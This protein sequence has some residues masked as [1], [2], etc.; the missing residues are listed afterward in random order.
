MTVELVVP[1]HNYMTYDGENRKTAV[2]SGGGA[3][4]YSHDGN[5]MRVVKSI[6][7]RTTTVSIFSGSSLRQRTYRTLTSSP[8]F[9]TSVSLFEES[10][11]LFPNNPVGADAGSRSRYRSADLCVQL[12]R[13]PGT[14]YLRKRLTCPHFPHGN[15]NL[16]SRSRSGG[17]VGNAICVFK[18]GGAH[19]FS[20]A[21]LACKLCRRPIVQAAVWSLFVVVMAPDCDL[22]SGV[23]HVF[24]MRV[25]RGLTGLDMHSSIFFSMHQAR[26]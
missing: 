21:C 20:I 4:S 16:A 5:G 12:R 6:T 1:Q 18:V 25:L 2:S 24:D 15:L 13:S 14:D 22:L 19:V 10:F 7:G 26:K 23:K 8:S 3:G 17:K 11:L 9:A